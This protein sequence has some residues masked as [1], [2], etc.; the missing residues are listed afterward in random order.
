MKKTIYSLLIAMMI[1][2]ASTAEAGN[3]KERKTGAQTAA[4]QE[5]RTV[6]ASK[7]NMRGL[8]KASKIV[9]ARLSQKGAV[10]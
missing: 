2:M 4:A 5:K 7:K 1:G 3:G 10:K 6:K 8:K 9:N